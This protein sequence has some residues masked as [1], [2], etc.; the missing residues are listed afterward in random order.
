MQEGDVDLRG[1]AKNLVLSELKKNGGINFMRANIKKSILDIIS[2][3][4]ENI[5]QKLDFDFM[6]P[7]HR[8]NKSKEIILV[9]QLIKEFLKFYEMEYTLPAFEN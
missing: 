9:C 1:E 7:L 6:T 4:K 8:L 2:R 5:K 3:E